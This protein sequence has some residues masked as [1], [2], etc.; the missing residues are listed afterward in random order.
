M[1][2]PLGPRKGKESRTVHQQGEA[3]DKP[4]PGREVGRDVRRRLLGL[5]RL[6]I[7]LS[8]S[9]PAASLSSP[10]PR[11]RRASS[12]ACAASCPPGGFA[13]ARELGFSW[14]PPSARVVHLGKVRCVQ[15]G[16]GGLGRCSGTLGQPPQEPHPAGDTSA[17]SQLS[18]PLPLGFGV[19]STS[20]CYDA[21][22]ESELQ[23]WLVRSAGYG[24][25]SSSA[26]PRTHHALIDDE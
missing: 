1:P 25:P 19:K 4:R 9:P 15:R 17:A 12:R 20:L 6:L 2:R 5:L 14:K 13:S 22:S 10:A 8:A 18:S 11:I 23:G 16:Q 7:P 3:D 26:A 24:S 21:A